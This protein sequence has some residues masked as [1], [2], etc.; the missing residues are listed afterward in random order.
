[1]A[2]CWRGLRDLAAVLADLGEKDKAA[3]LHKEA[4]AF[5]K[6]ILDAVTKSQDAK[7]K[8][9]PV[10]LLAGEKPHDPLTATRTG[11]YYD[12]MIPYVLDSGALG[13]E[14]EGWIIDYLRHHG[15]IAMG[16]IRSMPHQGQFNGEPG[17]NVLYG[18]RYNLTLLRRG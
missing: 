12:L 17:V 1:N 4:R 2:A 18:L 6:A 8:F 14:R 5:R 11:S 13:A 10:A 16:M 15:G 7:E 9:I 3:E